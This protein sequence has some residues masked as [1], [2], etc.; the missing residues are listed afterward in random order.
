VLIV[1]LTGGIGAGKTTLSESLARRGA[2]VIDVDG[3]GRQV[4]GHGGSAVDAV[5]ARFGEQVRS[6]DGDIDRAKLA[7]IVFNNDAA[8]GDLTAISHPAINNL[9]DATI[10]D[11]IDS[12][13]GEA[14][15]GDNSIIVLDMAVLVESSLGWENEHR[16]ELAIVV[17]SP[18]HLRFERLEARGMS[19]Q[20]IKDRIAA[21]ATDEQR[22]QAAQF[23]VTNGGTIDDL[24]TTAGEVWAELQR[25]HA[26]KQLGLTE[27]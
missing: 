10:D 13:T 7:E 26:E 16:Y 23:V 5:V 15:R 20:E 11:L 22:T 4:I 3:L 14:E 27:G 17:E 8:L 25:L 18:L 24:N 19:I 2:I 21:Q 12:E 6:E 9:I 1:G